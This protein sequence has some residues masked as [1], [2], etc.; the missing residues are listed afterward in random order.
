MNR[1]Y[2]SY[3]GEKFSCRHCGWIGTGKEVEEGEMFDDGFEVDC[4]KCQ[5]HFPGL[6]MFPLIEE[7]IEEGSKKDKLA[8]ATM[9]NSREKCLASL[10][11]STNKLPNLHNDIM[12][13]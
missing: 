1:D 2:Y 12:I 10:L 13:F 4:P 9:K 11:K 6:I 8:A 5:E 7:V 3:K